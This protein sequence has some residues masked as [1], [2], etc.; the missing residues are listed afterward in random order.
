MKNFLEAKSIIEANGG[1]FDGAKPVALVDAAR[2]ALG[3]EFPPSYRAFLLEL[4]CGDIN[5]FEVYGVTDGNFHD[6]SIPNG[7]WLTLT[8]REGGLP[9][10]YVLIGDRGDGSRY[11]IDTGSV[12]KDGES[13]VVVL[14]VDGENLETVSESFGDFLLDSVRKV[15]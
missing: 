4:G 2:K 9:R 8:E 7:I 10:Q 1:D 15:V 13:P 5:G 6:S 11:A 14:S 12:G 3:V